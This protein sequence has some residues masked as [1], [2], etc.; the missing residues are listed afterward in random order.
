MRPITRKIIFA[1]VLV[2]LAVVAGAI[3]RSRPL[4]TG[5]AIVTTVLFGVGVTNQ[6]KASMTV[7]DGGDGA[8]LWSYDHEVG[9]G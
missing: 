4:G 2:G 5:A 6:V 1:C 9:G 3:G 8:L 7:H